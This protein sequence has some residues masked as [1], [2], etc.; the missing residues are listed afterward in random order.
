MAQAMIYIDNTPHEVDA[1]RN[2]LDVCLSLRLDLPYFCWHPAMGSVG[3]CRQCA[4]KLFQN[5]HDTRGRLVMACMTPVVNGMR[6]SI[7]DPDA[8]KF[9]AGVIEGLMENHPHDCPVCDEGGECHLQDMTV[10]TGHDYRSYRF[11]KRTFRNQYLGPF[12]NHEMNRCIQCYRCVRFYREY[13][14]GDDFNVFKLRDIV[15]FG[16]KEDGVLQN[17]FAGNLVEV[18]PTGVF[19]DKTLKRHYARKWDLTMAPSICVHCG[20]GCNTTVAERYGQVRRIV[21]RY[22]G[23]VNGYFL[24]DRGRY[25]YEFVNSP[26][27][28]RKARSRL[29]GRVQQLNPAEALKHVSNLLSNKR[30]VLGIGSPRASL[31]ANFALRTLVGADHFYTGMSES[32]SQ[33]VSL[34]L[35]ILRDSPAS[36]PS[37]REVES[38]DAVFVLGEDVTNTAPRLALSLRQAARQRPLED[39]KK[40][41]VPLW[42][43]HAVRT[44]IQDRHGPFFV[45]CPSETRLDDIATQAYRAAPDDIARLAFAVAHEIDSSAP[46]APDLSRQARSFAERVAGALAN[47]KKPLVISGSASASDAL[48]Q[49]AANVVR[50]LSHAGKSAGLTFTMPEANSAGLALFGGGSLNGAFQAANK[51]GAD[52]TVIVLE[53]DLSRRAPRSEVDRFLSSGVHLIALDSLETETTARAEIVLPAGTFAESSGT[54]I[55]NEGRAQRFFRVLPPEAEILESWAW[56]AQMTAA[57]GERS[58]QDLDEII[59]AIAQSEPFLAPVT[60]AAPLS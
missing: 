48:I 20:L 27:R 60:K 23:S 15:Y 13:A 58:W 56:L 40:L 38:Y 55:N 49:A 26:H 34:M 5:E 2:L 32:E 7:A 33:L 21:N 6:I 12:L 47:S 42:Q 11:P 39:A 30:R 4:V 57:K 16:R 52:T 59:L 25:G 19:T 43:D 53:N 1:E 45:A 35:N 50:S 37:M 36:I 54:V 8:R 3:A 22:N 10:M 51:D 14:G 29:N 9:R 28:I 41:H 18:C 44:L 31:E 24:C 46:D 17:E